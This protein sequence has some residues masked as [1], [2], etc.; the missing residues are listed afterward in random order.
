M[1]SLFLR[2]IHLMIHPC[3]V[4]F[5]SGTGVANVIDFEDEMEH[6]PAWILSQKGRL[7]FAEMVTKLLED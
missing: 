5:K 2:V 6:L 4:F 1:K 3:L 7:D